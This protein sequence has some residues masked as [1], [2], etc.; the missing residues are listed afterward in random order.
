[1]HVPF[2]AFYQGKSENRQR[3]LFTSCE[4]KSGESLKSNHAIKL[5]I[6]SRRIEIT[7]RNWLLETKDKYKFSGFS[8]TYWK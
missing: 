6:N 1:M 2:Y 4:S 8:E 3:F 7:S 5:R